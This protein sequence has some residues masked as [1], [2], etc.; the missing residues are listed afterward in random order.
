MP[1]DEIRPSTSQRTTHIVERKS[2]SVEPGIWQ[3]GAKFDNQFDV[4]DVFGGP[5]VSGMGIVYILEANGQRRAAKT[6]QH[7]FSKNLSLVQRFLREAKTWLIAG[8]HPNI[9]QAY[10]LDIVEAM[11]YLFMEYVATD[12]RNRLSLADHIQ[13]GP[14]D[15]L[16]ALRYAIQCCEGMM[17][18][19]AAVPGL[20]HRDLKPENLLIDPDGVL[21]ITDLGLVRSALAEEI[22]TEE[23]P[24][25]P[26]D[27]ERL[28]RVGSAFGTPAYMPPEQFQSA[29][30]VTMAADIYA[31]GCCF[32]EAFSGQRLFT[33]DSKS[34]R[35]HL[36]DMKALHLNEEPVPLMEQAPGCHQ[37]LNHAIM[38]CLEKDP[39]HRWRNFGEVRDLLVDVLEG[40]HGVAWEP[41][42]RVPMVAA[43]I[44]EQVRA[45]SL[46]DGYSK[47]VQGHHLRASQDSRPYTFHLALSSFFRS[48]NEHT[49]EQRQLEKALR[50]ADGKEG[51]EAVRRMAERLV[52]DGELQR[53]DDT[54]EAYL[55]VSPDGVDHILEPFV[56]LH[57]ARGAY[58]EA[59]RLIN[60]HP[61]D[62]RVAVL[63]IEL[64]RASGR[65]EELLEFLSKEADATTQR[66]CRNLEGLTGEETVGWEYEHDATVLSTAM[67]LLDSKRDT[68]VLSKVQ[69]AVWPS[70]EGHP[71]FSADMAWL[72]RIAGDLDILKDHQTETTLPWG[73][74]ADLLNH[75]VRYTQHMQRDEDWFWEADGTG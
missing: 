25:E 48:R 41:P 24:T 26:S 9:V 52:V 38:R 74:I 6:F 19:T 50:I 33:I 66:L 39:A 28:T 75:P 67:Q 73:Q 20:V 71:D 55:S 15:Q 61:T 45:L 51:Y 42:S 1:N 62:R 35:G 7:H 30:T 56:R 57:I 65:F 5:G 4:R 8:T 2:T 69:H 11:P 53:A 36:S 49:E 14:I 13:Q 17:H 16:D 47:A 64:L 27:D 34:P 70:L 37:T 59:E 22:P 72:S 31:F 12:D 32:Y 23:M 54:M 43:D 44:A 58:D 63:R 3:V 46:I 18:A 60:S 10:S 68:A 21:K 40:V 29:D